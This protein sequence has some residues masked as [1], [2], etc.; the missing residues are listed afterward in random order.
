M[1]KPVVINPT[2]CEKHQV[3]FFLS[4]LSYVYLACS[5]AHFTLQCFARVT[6]HLTL[7]DHYVC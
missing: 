3:A 1:D 2:Y 6:Y 4:H 7:F 5:E